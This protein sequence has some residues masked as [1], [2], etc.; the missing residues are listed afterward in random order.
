MLS[1]CLSSD[2]DAIIN[3]TALKIVS[4]VLEGAERAVPEGNTA[5]EGLPQGTTL[6]LLLWVH[7][8]TYSLLGAWRA[9]Q[10]LKAQPLKERA[11]GKLIDIARV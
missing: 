10:F 8:M 9:P 5:A 7:S 3:K 1:A 2:T 4:P 6:L 11:F